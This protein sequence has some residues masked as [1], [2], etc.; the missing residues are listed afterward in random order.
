MIRNVNNE[1]EVVLVVEEV[2]DLDK[3]VL[4]VVDIRIKEIEP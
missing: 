2:V 3:V 4:D 1:E